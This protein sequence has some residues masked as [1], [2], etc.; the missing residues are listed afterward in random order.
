MGALRTVLYGVPGVADRM[1]VE[2]EEPY[3]IRNEQPREIV[4]AKFARGENFHYRWVPLACIREVDR[5]RGFVRQGL[6]RIA[7]PML[8]V[9]G[10]TS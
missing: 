6:Q 1:K 2:E 4:K 3:G 7:C 5:L 8:M 10:W 9:R